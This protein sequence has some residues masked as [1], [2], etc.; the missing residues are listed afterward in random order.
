MS[1]SENS[2]DL[3]E[4][5]SKNSH[6][7]KSLEKPGGSS[8]PP[9]NTMF[10]EASAD[11][12]NHPTLK[13]FIALFLFG[14][15]MAFV[16]S[17]VVVYLRTIWELSDLFPVRNIFDQPEYLHV[18]KVEFSREAATLIM[19]ISISIAL[20]RNIWQRMAYLLF[21]FGVWD[22]FYYVWLW[23]IIGWPASMLS[24]DVLFFIPYTLVSPVYAPVAVSA[25]MIFCGMMIIHAQRK[26]VIL[27]S[28]LRFWIME[29]LAFA[30]IYTSL[31]WETP[32]VNAGALEAELVYPWLPFVIGLTIGL[33][34]FLFLI[35]NCFKRKKF[36]F[37]L[38][39]SKKI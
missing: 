37:D 24:W 28:T 35:G 9:T 15:G 23:V 26:H 5:A 32:K 34:A 21:I 2:N 1:D 6:K 11:K 16:E 20:G 25:V 39:I 22:I 12:T 10:P 36:D 14:I 17:A 3:F 31:I 7:T 38:Y 18:L 4:W 8:Y 30:L 19:L 27:K 29:V 33:T 13:I